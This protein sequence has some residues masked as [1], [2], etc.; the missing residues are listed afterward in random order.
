MMGLL[1]IDSKDY[2]PFSYQT[3]MSHVVSCSDYWGIEFLVEK[4]LEIHV[5]LSQ[6][7]IYL[8]IILTGGDSVICLSTM[9]ES[10]CKVCS[11][12]CS[13]MYGNVWI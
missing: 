10:L 12:D 8:S 13:H 4:S 7:W 5:V 9:F 11:I 1:F 6:K 2:A 3:I